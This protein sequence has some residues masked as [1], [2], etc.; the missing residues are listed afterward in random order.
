MTAPARAASS[1]SPSS[2]RRSRRSGRSSL[3]HQLSGAH[4]M[5]TGNR[6]E[7]MAPQGVYPCAGDE[8]WVAL[9][10]ADDRQW[11]ALAELLGDDALGEQYAIAGRPAGQPRRARRAD[12]AMDVDRARP[13]EAA[14]RAAG[15]RDRRPRGDV[16][17]RACCATSRSAPGGGSSSSVPSGSR[18]ATCSAAT[19]S[20]S[21][22]RRASGGGPGRRW[23][24]T[25][26]MCSPG[27]PACRAEAVD[28]LIES[29]AAF[30]DAAPELKLRRPYVDDAEVRRR[31]RRR[32][33][34]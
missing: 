32:C 12:R 22:R 15:G 3:D 5:R 30:V 18:T 27:G 26:S 9:T 28:A 8:Q 31:A 19:P 29:G 10:V 13:T 20:T 6:L 23:A 33:A 34:A 14:T 2:R 11:L 7:W 4:A 17:P 16:Q 21:R 1:T 25:R 24:R